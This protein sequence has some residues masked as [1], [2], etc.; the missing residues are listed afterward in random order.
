[1]SSAAR[2]FVRRSSLFTA[3]KQTKKSVNISYFSNLK[4]LFI[5][6]GVLR[7]NGTLKYGDVHEKCNFSEMQE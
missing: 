3:E 2:M 7:G 6:A 1:M 4:F 5:T